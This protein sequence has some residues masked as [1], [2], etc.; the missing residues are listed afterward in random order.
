[1]TLVRYA[2]N[3]YTKHESR[4]VEL[5]E[6]IG[7]SHSKTGGLDFIRKA[8][9]QE[10]RKRD[11]IRIIPGRDNPSDVNERLTENGVYIEV[12]D[13][14]NL[15]LISTIVDEE[16]DFEIL[17]ETLRSYKKSD[18]TKTHKTYDYLL[19]EIIADDI[20]IYPPGKIFAK[21]NPTIN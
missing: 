5:K 10:S 15:V 16:K 17:L 4:Y 18:F 14:K 19:N 12:I 2:V 9:T 11:F 3:Y 8:P 7:W 13:D 20:M 21:K 6:I 1:M